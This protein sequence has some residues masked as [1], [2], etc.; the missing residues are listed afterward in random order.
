MKNGVRKGDLERKLREFI[1][2]AANAKLNVKAGRLREASSDLSA[3]LKLVPEK[4]EA[5][6]KLRESIRTLEKMQGVRQDGP[7]YSL[8]KA[9]LNRQLDEALWYAGKLM[10]ELESTEKQRAVSY[11]RKDIVHSL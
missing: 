8:L 10:D 4:S 3:C 7:E 5:A 1:E 6:L 2:K 11:L 9:H